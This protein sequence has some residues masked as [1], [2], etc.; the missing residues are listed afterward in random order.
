[1]KLHL[2]CYRNVKVQI[3]DVCV[4]GYDNI[5]CWMSPVSCVAYVGLS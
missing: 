2:G 5:C 4:V 1:M 3:R